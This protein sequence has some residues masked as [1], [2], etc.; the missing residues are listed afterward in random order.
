L[1]LGSALRSRIE[2]QI[3]AADAQHPVVEQA[4]LKSPSGAVGNSSTAVQEAVITTAEQRPLA[5][6]RPALT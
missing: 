3:A 4:Y 1:V 5:F 6:S 2:F